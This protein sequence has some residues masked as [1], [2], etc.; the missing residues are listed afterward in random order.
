M[1]ALRRTSAISLALLTALLAG[2]PASAAEPERRAP[3]GGGTLD[4][5]AVQ[6]DL[7]LAQRRAIQS[8]LDRSISDL[9]RQG[10]LEPPGE[11]A[12]RLTVW[13]VGPS[14]RLKEPNV[15]GIS[16]FVDHDGRNPGRVR[17]YFC[18]ERTYD[19]A[20]YDHG[21]TDIFSWPFGWSRMD[22]NDVRV[23]AAAP[24]TIVFKASGNPD[25]SCGFNGSDWNAV[26][27]RHADGTVAWYGHLKRNSLTSKAVG[28][29]VAAGE[30]LGVVGSSGS[31]TGPHLHLELHDAAGDVQDP[32]A[33]ACRSG[34]TRWKKQPP[35]YLPTINKVAT[36]GAPPE[37]PGCPATYD[38][39]NFKTSFA[40]GDA[41]VFAIYLRD[42]LAG[43]QVLYRL[44]GP[45]N[46][47]V[48]SWIQDGSD[49]YY[50]ASYW[51]WIGSI[52]DDAAAGTYRLR[53]DYAGKF[54]EQR[55]KVN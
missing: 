51:Y 46:T 7:T 9:E 35:Y 11:A 38:V 42:Q 18:G 28:A 40:R 8:D 23:V 50:V 29:K 30:F 6:D 31:S 47:L 14:S 39:E 2:S 25:R 19:L 21:G 15:Y 43:E 44:Y 17:D 13:P 41:I 5:R 32:F 49:V 33:G 24:G 48:D 22:R 3:N 36:H 4:A 53:V 1:N 12:T 52:P 10:L 37:F 55:Y 16:N 34:A 20:G 26:Y 27:V 54:L 45:G